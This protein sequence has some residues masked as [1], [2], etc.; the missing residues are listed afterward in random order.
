M[1]R[2]SLEDLLRDAGADAAKL[3]RS[4]KYH[5][6]DNRAS[7]GRRI[8]PQIPYEFTTWQRETWAW[9]QTVALFD[10]THHMWGVFVSG[11]DALK[12][13]S[14]LS[15][16]KLDNSTPNRAH[17]IIC[18]NEDGYLI[19][20]AILFHL[21]EG[22][23]SVYGAPFVPHWIQYQAELG[24]FDVKATPDPRSPVYA[25]GH[26]NIR[27]DCRYQIQGPNAA[28][29]IDKLNGGPL[30]E[31]KFFHMTEM[32]IAGH[33]VCALR[34]GMAGTPGLEIWAPYELRDDIRGAILE[35]GEEFGIVPVGAAAYLC[36]AIESGWI[37]AV[38]PAIFGPTTKGYREWLSDTDVESLVRLSG[39]YYSDKIEDYYRTPYGL[40]YGHLIK[41]EHD[42]IG[43]EALKPIDASMQ[44]RKVTLL[45]NVEDACKVFAAMLY[46]DAGNVRYLHLPF[47]DD[48]FDMVYDRLTGGD[49]LVGI[50][51]YTAYS[52]NES[53]LLTLGMVDPHI[54]LGSEVVLHWGEAGGGYG[55]GFVEPTKQIAVRATVSPAPYSVVARTQYAG[56][57]WR[58]GKK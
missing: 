6:K 9:R 57:G 35:A 8:I 26:A 31:V 39:S 56:G 7:E 34:H 5:I 3:M 47:V 2:R 41:L 18:C 58:A 43:R 28:K 48:K 37:H 21:N 22:Q 54:E 45:W 24:K 36:G 38:L 42:F 53:S 20:D 27:P 55:P 16:N 19:G 23:F 40:G 12:L 13:L 46:P 30:G 50:S 32:T 11:P 49:A 17:Q 1:A 51:H 4:T 15:C 52:A 10:Q 29:L 33:K 25:N 44:R 14:H